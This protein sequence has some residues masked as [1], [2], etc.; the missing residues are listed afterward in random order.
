M[1]T[2]IAPSLLLSTSVD[3][4]GTILDHGNYYRCQ[5]GGLERWDCLK[6]RNPRQVM[7]E[8][9]IQKDAQVYDYLC[10]GMSVYV[11]MYAYVWEYLCVYKCVCLCI[12]AFVYPH[13]YIY[14]HVLT[15]VWMHVGMSLCRW[16]WDISEC[17][18]LSMCTICLHVNRWLHYTYGCL[19]EYECI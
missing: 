13:V 19:W 12:H 18:G 3:I 1:P 7:N 14:V 11:I 8:K 9:P 4:N 17:K 15:Y 10:E 5:I 6:K 16:V 2:L